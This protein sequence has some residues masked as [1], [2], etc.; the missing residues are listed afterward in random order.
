MTSFGQPP[1]YDPLPAYEQPLKDRPTSVTVLSIIGIIW[2]IINLLCGGLSLAGTLLSMSGGRSLFGPPVNMPHW[3]TVTS[4]IAGLLGIAISAMLMIGSI[5]SLYLRPWARTL[6]MAWSIVTL[7][8]STASTVFQLVLLPET[9]A[10][11]KQSQPNNPA[12][13]GP[14]I[15]WWTACMTVL[16]WLVACVLPLCFLIL[17][18]KPAVKEAFEVQ[19]SDLR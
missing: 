1:A 12:M 16:A 18:N 19:K 11:I 4:L 7:L 15:Q 8:F 5:A 9:V 17:W 2:A 3:M 14:F 10:A 13:N 6:V